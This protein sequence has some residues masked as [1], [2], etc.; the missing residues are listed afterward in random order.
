[1]VK[2]GTMVVMKRTIDW[3]T[4]SKQ[5]IKLNDL[6]G[7]NLSWEKKE[8]MKEVKYYKLN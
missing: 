8:T 1:M 4:K 3:L 7:K 2:T 5:L 6:M